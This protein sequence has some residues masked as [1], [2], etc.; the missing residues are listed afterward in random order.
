[1]KNL[2][3]IDLCAGIGGFR[4]AFEDEKTHCNLTCEI[5][6][7]CE[8]S[9]LANYL[10]TSYTKDIKKIDENLLADFDILCAGFPCQAFSLAGKQKGFEDTRGTIFFDIARILKKKQPSAFLLENVKNL[11]L[12]K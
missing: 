11:E 6:N 10:E 12:L 7:F 9:Y 3:F 1:V 4:M 2:N 5:D 8:K